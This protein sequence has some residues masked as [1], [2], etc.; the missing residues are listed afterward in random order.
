MQNSV[1]RVRGSFGLKFPSDESEKGS[2]LIETD[3]STTARVEVE[4]TLNRTGLFCTAA[5]VLKAPQTNAARPAQTAAKKRFRE[6]DTR[7]LI[8]IFL[9]S[10][11]A[12]RTKSTVRPDPYFAKLVEGPPGNHTQV[13]PTI[14]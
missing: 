8:G 4:D 3:S 1:M 9:T 14:T 11:K 5:D 2:V 7:F 13:R 12:I 10:S 6:L